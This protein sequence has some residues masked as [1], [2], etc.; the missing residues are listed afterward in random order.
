MTAYRYPLVGTLRDDLQSKYHD[1]WLYVLSK[2]TGYSEDWLKHYFERC[3]NY[4]LNHGY[5]EFTDLL[6]SSESITLATET[7]LSPLH[8]TAMCDHYRDGDI[9]YIEVTLFGK[10]LK[11]EFK[12]KYG[13]WG[14]KI[15][16]LNKVIGKNDHWTEYLVIC[17]NHELDPRDL[18][19]E[20]I[21]WLNKQPCYNSILRANAN[22][23]TAM[24]FY[25]DRRQD[26][27]YIQQKR[28]NGYNRTFEVLPYRKFIE[29]SYEYK[30]KK[31]YPHDSKFM[32]DVYYKGFT[33][34]Y[35]NSNA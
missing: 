8:I 25:F 35:V 7:I 14:R 10:P 28:S 1:R 31:P 5:E 32:E 29:Q 15:P 18:L 27:R 30:F 13:C 4:Y 24:H 19:Q 34:A 9:K 12:D 23:Y 17:E 33:E 26:A 3:Q 20:Q 22:D 21:D 11:L 16:Q 6:S 2:Y